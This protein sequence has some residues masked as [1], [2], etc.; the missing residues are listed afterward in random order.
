MCLFLEVPWL[1]MC[2][3]KLVFPGQ[4]CLF[5]SYARIQEYSSGGGG[6]YRGC[7]MVISRITIFQ[8]CGGAPTLFSG[9]GGPTL[10]KGSKSYL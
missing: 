5:V 8:G 9:V 4:I 3:V 10:F 6:G 1:G 2:S 7:S